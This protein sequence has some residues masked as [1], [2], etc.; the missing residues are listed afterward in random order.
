MDPKESNSCDVLS[1]GPQDSVL[2][3][4]LFLLYVNDIITDV[5]SKINLFADECALYR[6][7]K[8]AEDTFALQ[9]DLD[10][11]Y[12]WN[13]DWDMDFNVSKCFSMS[14]TLKR[15]IITSEYYISDELAE[16]LQSYKYLGVYICNDM[17]WNKTVDLVV[18][19]ANRSLGLLRRNCST[20]SR[21]IREKAYFA[22]V[23]PHLEYAC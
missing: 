1:S 13:C 22:L 2:S 19:K 6:E 23:R 20:C 21:Q 8:S 10:R 4:V 17:R 5:D 15:N 18:G 7:I 16:K 3:P 9:K 14:V 11:L 12:R